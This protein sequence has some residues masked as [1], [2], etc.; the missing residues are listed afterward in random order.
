MESQRSLLVIA[1][2]FVS[3]LLWQ[4]WQKDY[5]PKPVVPA[6]TEVST[7]T[8]NAEPQLSASGPLSS[9]NQ[10]ATVTA[11]GKVIEVTTDVL[12]VKIDTRG[13]DIVGLT[14]P[15]YT[16]SLEDSTPYPLMRQINGFNYT[17]QSGLLGDGP[18]E[19]RTAKPVYSVAQDKFSLIEG[20]TEL[21]VSLNLE[22]NGLNIE[23]R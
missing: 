4:D 15:K 17:A 6:Q 10:A 2:L 18:D 1:F 9:D 14:L 21:Q 8:G 19:K 23:K 20:Q 13:G 5:G 22:H 7:A 3:F 12:N 11:T 16:L